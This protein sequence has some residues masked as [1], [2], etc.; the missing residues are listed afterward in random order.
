LRRIRILLADMPRLLLEL[1]DAII[2]AEPDML[3]V[4][5]HFTDA[6]L[7]GAA[8][9]TDADIVIAGEGDT[10]RAEQWISLLY[11]CPQLKVLVLEQTGRTALLYELRPHRTSLGEVSRSGLL[12]AIRAAAHDGVA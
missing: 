4:G 3:I 7:P 1:V 2:S 8:T 10:P 9:R 5:E 12:D 11:Q 6:E